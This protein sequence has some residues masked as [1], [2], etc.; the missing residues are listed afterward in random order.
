MESSNIPVTICIQLIGQINLY[1]KIFIE[2]YSLVSIQH[3]HRKLQTY[4]VFTR[5]IFISCQHRYLEESTQLILN[6]VHTC[7]YTFLRN[8][9]PNNLQ[10]GFSRKFYFRFWE[11]MNSNH[12]CA[13]RKWV[14][15]SFQFSITS[16]YFL[17]VQAISKEITTIKQVGY[18][19]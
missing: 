13:R 12:S 15:R 1:I 8:I 2:K 16:N 17:L 4:L 6:V 10:R 11:A 9:R 7:V 3:Y 18:K 14:F 5:T 19:D